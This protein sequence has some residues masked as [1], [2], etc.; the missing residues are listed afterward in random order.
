MIK[1]IKN[2]KNEFQMKAPH[3]IRGSHFRQP[4]DSGLQVGQCPLAW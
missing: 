3:Q 4:R 2:T 1:N